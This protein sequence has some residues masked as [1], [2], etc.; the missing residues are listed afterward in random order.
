MSRGVEDRADVLRHKVD[1][2]HGHGGAAGLG[3]AH[4]GVGHRQRV[5][6][7]DVGT[8][9]VVVVVFV[10]VVAVSLFSVF[11]D[12]G[13]AALD[14]GVHVEVRD[15]ADALFPER[16]RQGLYDLLVRPEEAGLGL[17]EGAAGLEPA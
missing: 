6:D 15:D 4:G 17:G 11:G 7:L 8:A 1:A 12:G 9:G 5:G 2:E 3:H 14:L 13:E 16:L 10:A